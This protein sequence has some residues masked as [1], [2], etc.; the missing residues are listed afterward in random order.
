M[1][2]NTTEG[3][4]RTSGFGSVVYTCAR[5]GYAGEGIRFDCHLPVASLPRES[6]PDVDWRQRPARGR[7]GSRPHSTRIAAASRGSGIGGP[8][9]HDGWRLVDV[10]ARCA[11]KRHRAAH[12]VGQL[13]LA[14]RRRRRVGVD[15]CAVGAAQRGLVIHDNSAAGAIPARSSGRAARGPALVGGGRLRLAPE[16]QSAAHG[17]SRPLGSLS[18]SHAALAASLRWSWS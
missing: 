17:L 4:G 10:V 15:R 11:P 12:E 14:V 2:V 8:G 1:T 18:P 7:G 9:R 5:G 13:G 16:G 6:A 3:Y